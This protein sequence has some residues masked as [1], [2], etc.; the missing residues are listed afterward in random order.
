MRRRPPAIDREA[1]DP[2][3]RDYLR[4]FAA[5]GGRVPKRL[6]QAADV[7]P[8]W[9]FVRGALDAAG[10]VSRPDKGAH[11][12]RCSLALEPELAAAVAS[13]CGVPCEVR[14]R[15]LVWRGENALDLLARLYD[16]ATVACRS[17]RDRYLAW[18]A[19]SARS[20]L[21]LRWSRLHPAA[22]A[23]RKEHASDCGYDVTLVRVAEVRGA[24]T[25]YGSGV[26]VE[27]PFGW[28]FDLVARSSISKTGHLLANGIGVIDRAYRGEL[29]VPLVKIDPAAPDLRLPARIVQL[30]PRPIVHLQVVERPALDGTRR[31]GGGFGSTG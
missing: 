20:E 30:V 1:L 26:Q 18:T 5:A 15:K 19:W 31:G 9:P 13:F 8:S 4:G 2:E 21:E 23:P 28:Y 11:G 17:P 25:F 27:P 16:D 22:V 24:V 12:P 3:R 29:L 7:R 14:R 10:T 6:A